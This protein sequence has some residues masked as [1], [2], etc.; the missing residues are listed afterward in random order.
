MIRACEFVDL[1]CIYM[2]CT[3]TLPGPKGKRGKT[4]SGDDDDVVGRGAKVEWES[5]CSVVSSYN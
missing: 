1:H 4:R 5:I 3:C 2:Y